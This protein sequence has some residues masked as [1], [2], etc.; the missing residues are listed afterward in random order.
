MTEA[1][2]AERIEGAGR[3]KAG[4]RRRLAGV[5]VVLFL[6]LFPCLMALYAV[7]TY[8]W[9]VDD[10]HRVGVG[11]VLGADFPVFYTAGHE[12][13]HGN[14]GKLYDP[15]HMVAREKALV[16]EKSPA[17]VFFYPPYALFL[18]A[19]LAFFSYLTAFWVWTTATV[20]GF[21]FAAHRITG[22]WSAPLLVPLAPSVV[23]GAAA[24]QN[25]LVLA[26][27]MATGMMVLAR[28][29]AVGGAILGLAAFK[30][31]L[32]VVAPLLFLLTGQWRAL[33]GY[34]G[35]VLGLVLLSLLVF[36]IDIWSAF[37]ERV[38]LPILDPLSE[39][40]VV[41]SG[42]YEG[43]RDP[44]AFWQRVVAVFPLSRIVI[45]SPGWAMA[46]QGVA[47]VAA[48]GAALVVWRRTENPTV[49]TLALAAATLLAAP[50]ALDYDMVLYMA[51]LAFLYKDL[52]GGR[53][54]LW[55]AA[56]MA[57][58]WS[59]ALTRWYALGLGWQPGPLINAGVL[60][61][62][63]ALA[64]RPPDGDATARGAQRLEP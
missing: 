57:V 11:D 4:R 41:W 14:T 35:M 37:I 36:G 60:A 7:P 34:I 2:P 18:W 53:G 54:S 21:A 24:G 64:W 56:L 47:S 46:V 63:V 22:H 15:R 33:A 8:F 62:A 40:H 19:P 6:A 13:V 51:P 25:G 12:A 32:A 55:T 58:L 31:H 50:K 30:P 23:F 49:R 45:G 26:V 10:H 9:P 29:P 44:A 16:S 28:R 39:R 42:L 1:R 3:R 5:G 48:V 38:T 59:A 20:G 17:L 61:A 27:I 52:L 43:A